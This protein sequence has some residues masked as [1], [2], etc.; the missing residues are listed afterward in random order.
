MKINL[1]LIFALLISIPATALADSRVLNVM[2][3]EPSKFTFVKKDGTFQGDKISVVTSEGEAQA[4]IV[5]CRKRSCLGQLRDDSTIIEKDMVVKFNAKKRRYAVAVSV[6][7]AL[8]LTYGAAFYYNFP[9][10]PWMVGVKI[11]Q[12]SNETNDIKLSGQIL[13]LEAQRFLKNW[14][15]FQIW[16]TSEVGLM[17]F[18]MDVTKVNPVESDIKETEYFA[19][20]GIEGRYNLT[21]NLRIIGGVG[22]IYNTLESTYSGDNSDYDLEVSNFYGMA[23]LGLAYFF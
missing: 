21:N 6:D 12:I 3:N 15:R 14:S 11:R 9:H 19:T 1:T 20:L 4:V 17:N 22:M 13:S 23:K 16:A 5:E 18:A 8:G 2:K 10:A 7:N